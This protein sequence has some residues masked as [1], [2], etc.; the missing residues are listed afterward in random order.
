MGKTFLREEETREMGF[1]QSRC[2]ISEITC[3]AYLDGKKIR[4]QK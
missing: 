2:L 4:Q 3:K 1:H